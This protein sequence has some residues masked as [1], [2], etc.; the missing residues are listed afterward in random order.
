ML[1]SFDNLVTRAGNPLAQGFDLRAGKVSVTV[2]MVAAGADY[3][4]VC[5]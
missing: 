1:L 5:K 2:P 4:I 3:E